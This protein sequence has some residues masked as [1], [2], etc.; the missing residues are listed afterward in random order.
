MVDTINPFG[1]GKQNCVGQS[2]AKAEIFSIVA[3]IIS[4]FDLSVEDD[5]AV[6]FFLTIKPVGTMLRARRV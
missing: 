4:E 1:L 5:G 3:K 6:D 2:L